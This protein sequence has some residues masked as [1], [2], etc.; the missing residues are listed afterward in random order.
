MRY[1]SR[2]IE[3]EVFSQFMSGVS[4]LTR[5][6]NWD[7]TWLLRWWSWLGW[8]AFDLPADRRVSLR[9]YRCVGHLSLWLGLGLCICRRTQLISVVAACLPVLRV[10]ILS[11]VCMAVSPV[12]LLQAHLVAYL[13]DTSDGVADHSCSEA[14]KSKTEPIQRDSHVPYLQLTH[15]LA[16]RWWH[17]R[18]RWQFLNSNQWV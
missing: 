6:M 2:E 3:I 16:G 18:D 4:W 11:V 7:E 12:Q 9:I 13:H 5:V 15:C 14:R 17:E 1:W 8:S 10:W